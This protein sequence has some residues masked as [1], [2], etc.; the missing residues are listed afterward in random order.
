MKRLL[1]LLLTQQVAYAGDLSHQPAA[2]VYAF[3]WNTSAAGTDA[4][5]FTRPDADIVDILNG[6]LRLR[7]LDETLLVS[8]SDA[9][10]TVTTSA[11]RV[12]PCLTMTPDMLY[13]NFVNGTSGVCQA[14]AACG[15]NLYQLHACTA[16]ADTVCVSQ[17]P[18]GTF[19]HIG[20]TQMMPALGGCTDCAEGTYSAS[21]G[22]S[23]CTACASNSIAPNMGST[24]C[25][26]CGPGTSAIR[27][28]ICLAVRTR[29]HIYER[30]LLC[31]C[32]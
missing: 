16:S 1:L 2:V 30:V 6:A 25:S 32:V 4:R 7:G 3:T 29:C 19:A 18:A 26:P 24:S 14:C 9:R 31:A 11:I 8:G 17:C 21:A 12:E 5:P 10:W 28:R 20:G 27:A 15:W 23:A 22:S 13:W